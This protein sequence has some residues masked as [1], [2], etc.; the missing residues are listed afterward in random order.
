[1]WRVVV[2]GSAPNQVIDIYDGDV[3]MATCKEKYL[4]DIIVKEQNSVEEQRLEMIS[5]HS[6]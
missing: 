3:W 1:M 4:A 5:K 6:E 2:F